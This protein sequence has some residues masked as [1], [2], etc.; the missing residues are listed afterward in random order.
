MVFYLSRFEGWRTW[1]PVK[2]D[3][4]ARTV[5]CFIHC[6]KLLTPGHIFLNCMQSDV[7]LVWLCLMTFR[8]KPIVYYLGFIYNNRTQWNSNLLNS[9]YKT[10]LLLGNWFSYILQYLPSALQWLKLDI[11]CL[12][13]YY[14]S[15]ILIEL[16]TRS[17]ESETAPSATFPSISV[18]SCVSERRIKPLGAINLSFMLQMSSSWKCP[19]N[20]RGQ[21][22]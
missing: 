3:E 2:T 12:M 13:V 9:D 19:Q 8:I 20:D 15:V 7:M 10:F 5:F 1:G 14:Y 6:L 22:L 21:I 18:F 16:V 11:M 17:S 4:E